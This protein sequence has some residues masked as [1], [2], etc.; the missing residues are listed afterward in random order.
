MEKREN[1]LR[2]GVRFSLF[3]TSYA[4]LFVLMIIG[5]IA[6]NQKELEWDKIVQ[7]GFSGFVSM[8]GLSMVLILLLIVGFGGLCLFIKRIKQAATISGVPIRV[9]DVKNRNS[10]AISYIGT[11]IIPFLF[12]NYNSSFEILSVGILL[13]VIYYIYI[14]S[15]LMLINPVLNLRYSL[16]EIDFID[17][18][19]SINPKVKVGLV[20]T[21]EKYLQDGD[22]LLMKNIGHKLYF[23]ITKEA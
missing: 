19:K 5:Q 7:K 17:D 14:N 3:A 23:A 16:F 18:L 1:R 21:R 22:E 15:T 12:Q 8:F 13:V 6:K 20:I 9:I 2:I 11:Y 10:E 4:P